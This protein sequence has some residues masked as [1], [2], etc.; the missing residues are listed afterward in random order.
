M[1]Q[2][3]SSSSFSTLFLSGASGTVGHNVAADIDVVAVP[4]A[5]MV[6]AVALTV[7]T[8]VWLWLAHAV[9]SKP[10]TPPPDDEAAE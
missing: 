3:S 8:V 1:P 9:G 4:I 10:G 2:V 7:V 5:V 6:A